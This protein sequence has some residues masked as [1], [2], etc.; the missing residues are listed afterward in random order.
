MYKFFSFCMKK[1][2]LKQKKYLK[3]YELPA[4]LSGEV[5]LVNIYNAMIFLHINISSLLSKTVELGNIADHTKPA[6]LWITKWKH[7]SFVSEQKVKLMEIIL[8]QA[9]NGGRPIAVLMVWNKFLS[10]FLSRWT[11]ILGILY[12][13]VDN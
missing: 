11:L 5:S 3:L 7:D 13:S 6:N 1:T 10:K 8:F 12:D 2:T 4:L 9:D